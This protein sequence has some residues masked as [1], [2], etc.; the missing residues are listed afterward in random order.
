LGGQFAGLLCVEIDESG[1][2]KLRAALAALLG[3]QLEII[4]H[5]SSSNSE[6]SCSEVAMVEIIGQDQPGIVKEI[7]NAFASEGVNV[8]ELS[9]HCSSAPMSG[10]R[11]FEAKAKVCIPESC[12]TDKLRDRLESIAEDLQVDVS[13]ESLDL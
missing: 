7:T 9:S 10:E 1:V 13:F 3:Q 5:R 12:D 6:S 2:E 4:V 8:E 11:L